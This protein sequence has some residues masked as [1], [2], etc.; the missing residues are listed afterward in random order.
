[1]ICQRHRYFS[2]RIEYDGVYR[3]QQW[4][5]LG[6]LVWYQLQD[7][8]DDMRSVSEEVL[9]SV[10]DDIVLQRPHL[11][12]SEYFPVVG[13][14]FFF[15]HKFRRDTNKDSKSET[16]SVLDLACMLN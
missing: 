8:L 13:S 10:Q 11:D 4:L 1:M 14:D 15:C 12:K 6:G 7:I 16:I 3:K 5:S 2:G 9:P